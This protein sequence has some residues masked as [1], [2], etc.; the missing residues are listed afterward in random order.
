MQKREFKDDLTD[1]WFKL[2]IVF[3]V[4]ILGIIPVFLIFGDFLAFG[5]AECTFHKLVHLYCPG[6]GGTR[7]VYYLVHGHFF[8]SFLMNPFVPFTFVDYL[9]FMINTILV[10]KTKKLGFAGFPVTGTI[11][12]GIGILLGQWIIRNIIYVAFK[13]TCL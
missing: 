4:M 7:S 13:I 3:G 1:T 10:K 2:G 11:Y 12:A 8:K 9:V 6:C 5:G